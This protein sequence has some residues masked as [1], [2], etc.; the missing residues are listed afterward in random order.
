MKKA[1]LALILLLLSGIAA[2]AA[3]INKKY[4]T[5]LTE[6]GIIYF[7]MPQKMTKASGSN[8]LKPMTFDI[9][10]LDKS[11]TVLIRGTINSA[12]PLHNHEVTVKLGDGVQFKVSAKTLFR[13]IAKNGFNN[14]VEMKLHKRDF[15]KMYD[16]PKPYVL[17]FGQQN[18]FGYAA[19]KWDKHRKMTKAIYELM[20]INQ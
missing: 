5:H 2:E 3:N 18:T 6:K 10:L 17:D 11:D 9:T 12:E 20:E 1:F 7:I 13:D 16:S 14:R 8:A 4:K 19:K 15:C